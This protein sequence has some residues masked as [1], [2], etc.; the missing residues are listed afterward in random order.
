M[1]GLSALRQFS[2]NMEPCCPPGAYT[3][4]RNVGLGVLGVAV[5]MEIALF[6]GRRNTLSKYLCISL[7]IRRTTPPEAW[8]L[9]SLMEVSCLSISVLDLY[10]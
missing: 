10:L 5:L 6:P 3:K 8:H 1:V 9:C 7:Q 2:Q 4:C